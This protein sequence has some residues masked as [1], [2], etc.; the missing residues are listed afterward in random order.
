MV[1]WKHFFTFLETL[2]A[3]LKIAIMKVKRLGRGGR[4]CSQKQQ[5]SNFQRK[6]KRKGKGK[7]SESK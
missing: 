5:C 4:E 1:H 2:R 3:T 6:A 7:V